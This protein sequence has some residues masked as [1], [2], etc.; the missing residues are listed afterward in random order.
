VP[1]I[2]EAVRAVDL[3]K[4]AAVATAALDAPSAA[5]VRALLAT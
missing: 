1:T 4:A 2:K 3:A 5:A